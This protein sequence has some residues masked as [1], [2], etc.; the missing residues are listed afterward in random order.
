[1]TFRRQSVMAERESRTA[2][3]APEARIAALLADRVPSRR[4]NYCVGP[5]RGHPALVAETSFF[6]N[7][8]V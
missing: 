6:S 3:R 2:Q 7:L 1:M 4:T 8:L 5:P